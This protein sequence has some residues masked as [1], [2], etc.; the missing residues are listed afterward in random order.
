[1]LNNF[2]LIRNIGKFD[3]VDAGAHLNL[4][5]LAL[6]Y[7]ENGRGK[8]TLAS[9]LRS[10]GSKQPLPIIE[11]TRLGGQGSPH[12]VIR[13][14]NSN[15]AI[16]QNDVW[17]N[18][19][20][21]IVVFDD[22]FVSDNIY[23]GVEVDTEHRQNL[24]E[25]IIGAEGILL[26]TNLQQIIERVELHNQALREKS[27][28]I[29]AAM[30]HGFDVDVFCA[31]ENKDDLDQLIS[32]AERSLSAAKK[33]ETIAQKNKIINLSLPDIDTE[34]V[35]SLL[36]KSLSDIEAVAATQVQEQIT[37][38]GEGG[39]GW[40]A[41][42][43]KIID[44]LNSSVCPFCKQELSGSEIISH[45][46]SIFSQQYQAL[47]QEIT[48]CLF[49]F[50]LNHR[51]E[52]MTAFER[53]VRKLSEDCQFW[54]EF[55]DVPE[56]DLDTAVITGLWRSS[57]EAINAILETKK[58]SPLEV[59]SLDESA[60]NFINQYREA[61]KVVHDLSSSL[62]ALNE[63]IDIIKEGAA[64][65]SVAAL[66]SDL[67]RLNAVK[68]RFTD[69]VSAFC[70]DYLE[71]KRLKTATEQERNE[72]RAALTQY[73]EQVFPKYQEAINRYLVKFNAGYRLDNISS[74]NNRR[75]SSCNYSVLIEN[76]SVPL[77]STEV[78]RPSFKTT[79]SSGDRNALALAFFFASIEMNANKGNIV[80]IIDDPMTSLD[81][82]R[83][84]TTIQQINELVINVDQVIV[85]SHSKP[86]LCK[87]YGSAD[88]SLSSAIKISRLG[89]SSTL[90]EWDVNQDSITEHDRN[91]V[92]VSDFIKN[93]H[94]ADE[95]SIAAA[96]RPILESY[97]RITCPSIFPPG[98]LLGPF[99]HICL[100]RENTPGQIIEPAVRSELRSLLDYAN[101]F[102]HD[103]NA[104][105]QTAGINDQELLDHAR[106]TI[107]FISM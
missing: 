90:S 83:S 69:A 58:E 77:S 55:I 103:T 50:K 20:V 71:E 29:T 105:W 31:L 73:R 68:S 1:M 57:Y 72:A 95:R 40:I 15:S 3:S 21:D 56:I 82:H 75:G 47:K 61:Q 27:D 67:N 8:T 45:Y 12:V 48:R 85:L 78:G 5:K 36:E 86:F 14:N 39:E 2:S 33:A 62:L 96:L 30:R 102:H 64:G 88:K 74:V 49:P 54:A 7:A 98:S 81:D 9:I 23:S 65:S 42:G 11:R 89:S 104:A 10:L 106:R 60:N 79:L 19:D 80:A 26:N 92:M 101:Q 84:L 51:T 34:S 4:N 28:R 13:N 53:N 76:I 32:D 18:I 44:K 87:L 6:I 70:E 43:M 35:N 22:H 37:S 63:K 46:Q 59:F 24:H 97:V 107:E 91:F 93:G 16:F 100:Q 99:L 17:N 66:E 94:D 38:L 41:N 25:L 52:L